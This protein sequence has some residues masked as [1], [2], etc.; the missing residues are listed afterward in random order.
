MIGNGVAKGTKDAKTVIVDSS[1]RTFPND[2]KLNDDGF[3]KSSKALI[4]RISSVRSEQKKR[5]FRKLWIGRT[6]AASKLSGL[7]C[8]KLTH[9]FKESN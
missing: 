1:A 9:D 2:R 5:A 3:K 8:R 7:S 4:G 6:D